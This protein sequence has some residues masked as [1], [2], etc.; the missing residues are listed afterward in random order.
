MKSTSPK[1]GNY[2]ISGAISGAVSSFIFVVIHDIVISDIWF[3]LVLMLIAG[4][5]CGLSLGWTYARITKAPT[6]VNWAAFNSVFVGMY[7]LLGLTSVLIFDPITTVAVLIDNNEPPG[8]LIGDALPVTIAFTIAAAVLITAIYDRRWSSFGSVLLTCLLLVLTLGLNV[9]IIGLVAFPSG[10]LYLI[11]ELFG[12]IFSLGFVFTAVF[13]ILERK[14]F[15][16]SNT[17]DEF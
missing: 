14:R 3:S 5:I 11:I 15:F 8:E 6:L 10:T 17:T 2:E 4:T 16:S 12:L 1:Q 9:S 7:G 13:L